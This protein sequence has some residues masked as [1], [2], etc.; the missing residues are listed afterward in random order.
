MTKTCLWVIMIN[1]IILFRLLLK[2]TM[3][4]IDMKVSY[5]GLWKFLIDHDMKKMD[6]VEELGIRTSTLEE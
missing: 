2:I 1:R 3:C 5:N 6:L 4:S